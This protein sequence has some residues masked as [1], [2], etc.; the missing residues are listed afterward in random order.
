MIDREMV[1]LQANVESNSFV[2]VL[3][4]GDAAYF[5][6]AFIQAG[7]TGASEAAHKLLTDIKIYV[8]KLNIDPELPIFVQIYANIGGLSGKLTHLGLINN[9]S[10]LHVGVLGDPADIS[11]CNPAMLQA[12]LAQNW[13]DQDIYVQD[14]VRLRDLSS[15]SREHI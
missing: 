9:P 15:Y 4:D 3:I 13:T 8:Q 7:A 6:D 14:D 11:F 5:H 2:Q 12:C 10:D 1:A